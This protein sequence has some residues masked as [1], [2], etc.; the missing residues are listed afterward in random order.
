MNLMRQ[1]TAVADTSMTCRGIPASVPAARE[2]VRATLAD[3]P[4]IYDLELIAAELITNAIYHT[5]SGHEGGTFRLTV[6][7]APGYARLEVTDQGSGIWP[8]SIPD[9]GGLPEGGRGLVVVAALADEVGHRALDGRGHVMWA[10][11]TW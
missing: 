4:R 1:A 2:F 8:L 10:V 7:Y 6:R 9:S 11:V 5:S 3:S